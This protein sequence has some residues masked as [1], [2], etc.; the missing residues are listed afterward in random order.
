MLRMRKNKKYHVHY[1]NFSKWIKE[2]ISRFEL[3]ERITQSPYCDFFI[4]E[5][6]S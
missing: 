4:Y 6:T 5:K 3:I 1:R 2:N